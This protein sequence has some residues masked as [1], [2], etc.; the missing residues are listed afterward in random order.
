MANTPDFTKAMQDMM[1][2]FPVN[3]GSFQDALKVQGAISEKLTRV[4]LDAA[5]RSAEI[6]AR[7]TKDSI[8]RLSELAAVKNDPADYAKSV[9]DFTS[10]SAEIAAAHMSAYAEIAK[11]AQMDTVDLMLSAG[12]DAAEVQNTAAK[13]TAKKAAAAAAGK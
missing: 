8:E 7:W 10:A 9:S 6:S 12:K 13:T 1:A 5:E 11:K 2:G 4:M 3:T